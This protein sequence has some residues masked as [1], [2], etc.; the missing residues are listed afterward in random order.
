MISEARSEISNIQRMADQAVQ[1]IVH[2]ARSHVT[3][4]QAQAQSVEAR[5]QVYVNELNAKHQKE[6]EE[7]Q[8]VAQRAHDECQVSQHQLNLANDRVNELLQT[9]GHQSDELERQ[10]R[11]HSGLTQ[12]ILELQHQVTLIRQSS[13]IPVQDQNATVIDMSPIM[14]DFKEVQSLRNELALMRQELEDG[15][16]LLWL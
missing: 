15:I 11:E 4:A 10:R 8:R 9:I 14:K 3:E 7:V 2:E 6:L 5:A 1:N 13:S 16:P 12:Q